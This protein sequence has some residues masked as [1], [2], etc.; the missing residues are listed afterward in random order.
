MIN[1]ILRR[2]FE[3]ALCLRKNNNISSVN[4][5]HSRSLSSE[6]DVAQAVKDVYYHKNTIWAHARGGKGK[7]KE[8]SKSPYKER[9]DE[10]LMLIGH[11]IYTQLNSNQYTRD[12]FDRFHSNL[13]DSFLVSINEIRNS[14][15]L[16]NMSYGQA[17]KLIN[18]S[19]KYLT[20][21][22]DYER[23]ADKFAQC[24]MVIDNIILQ[25]IGSNGITLLFGRVNCRVKKIKEGKYD[26]CSWTEMSKE[27]YQS[28]VNDYRCLVDPLLNGL[29]SDVTY[30]EIEYNLW[31]A[32]GQI[33]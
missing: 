23:Y 2:N 25:S 13:C 17:Q 29:F 8:T 4:P 30:M 11:Q 14:A 18:L 12:A 5:L 24:H 27:K 10:L 6:N 31:P 1:Q 26:G 16:A 32:P 3:R 20:C 28:L 21:Y 15:R 33:R 19:Y 9:V 7:N 22:S